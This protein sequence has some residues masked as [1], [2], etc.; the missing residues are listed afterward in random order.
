MLGSVKTNVG[1]LEA[2]AGGA[3]LLK[4]ILALEHGAIPPSLHFTRMN[5]LLE[6]FA[7][8]FAVVTDL[9]PWPR[10]ARP[11]LAGI[12]SMGM[13]GTN[14]H[15]VI[16]DAPSEAARERAAPPR[17]YQL[18]CLSARSEAALQKREGLSLADLKIPAG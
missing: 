17:P 6:P 18:L 1:H 13:S 7:D 16:A 15:L 8:K 3:A 14:A 5:P 11:R 4:V 9:A 10:G 12:T 2:A